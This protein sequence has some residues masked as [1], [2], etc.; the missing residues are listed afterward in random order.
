MLLL[1]Q[2][3]ASELFPSHSGADE[4]TPFQRGTDEL[5]HSEA[6]ATEFPQCHE[7]KNRV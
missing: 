6:D 5:S 2:P 7:S 1:T 3:G 4:L